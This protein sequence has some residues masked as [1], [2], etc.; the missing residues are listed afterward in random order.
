MMSVASSKIITIFLLAA[1]FV[2]RASASQINNGFEVIRNLDQQDDFAGSATSTE[3]ELVLYFRRLQQISVMPDEAHP[4]A[5][6]DSFLVPTA[7]PSSYDNLDIENM[8]ELSLNE[9]VVIPTDQDPIP[10]SQDAIPLLTVHPV[11]QVPTFSNRL[12]LHRPRLLLVSNIVRD[13]NLIL[14]DLNDE[15]EEESR[16]VVW[17]RNIKTIKSAMFVLGAF[18]FIYLF[19]NDC[20]SNS[21]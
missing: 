21:K 20:V 17:K 4:V 3:V 8:G 11:R 9:P 2:V 10:T 12:R 15:E 1:L 16:R 13:Q 19:I 18:A 14:F 7:N 6:A 5:F